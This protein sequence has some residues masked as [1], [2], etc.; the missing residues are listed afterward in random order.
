MSDLQSTRTHHRP[1]HPRSVLWSRGCYAGGSMLDSLSVV[2]RYQDEWPTR[3]AELIG[4]LATWYAAH[5]SIDETAGEIAS[6]LH[7][8]AFDQGLIHETCVDR[9]ERDAAGGAVHIFD[10]S[11]V[12]GDLRHALALA[13]LERYGL[14]DLV[15][16]A[17]PRVP[18]V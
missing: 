18:T 3:V 7:T 9:I 17:T 6:F 10:S 8:Q 15:H 11:I 16:T 4:D 2:I 1:R 13:A 14:P 5:P 12:H